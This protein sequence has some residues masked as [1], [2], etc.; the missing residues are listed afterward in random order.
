MEVEALQVF[1]PPSSVMQL[2]HPHRNFRAS[3]AASRNKIG[4]Y[5]RSTEVSGYDRGIWGEVGMRS[6]YVRHRSSIGI[7][8]IQAIDAEQVFD[9]AQ[10]VHCVVVRRDGGTPPAVRRDH[11]ANGAVRIDVIAAVL[12]IIFENK[13]GSTA[14]VWRVADE[15]DNSS[16]GV[17][18]ISY[19][20]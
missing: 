11:V 9:C 19:L 20:Q 17:V 2:G 13:N 14:P 10:N 16:D 15:L 5:R 6:E 1:R 3:A 18:V 8:L 4:V 7:A 12:R